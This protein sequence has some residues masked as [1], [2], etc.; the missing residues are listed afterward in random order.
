MMLLKLNQPVFDTATKTWGI[1]T[2]VLI[3]ASHNETYAFQPKGL[4]KDTGL[5]FSQI[6]LPRARISGGKKVL[7]TKYQDAPL[8]ILGTFV[9]DVPTGFK[10]TAISLYYHIT[11]CVHVEI[12]PTTTDKTGNLVTAQNFDI[13]RL[14][15]KFVPKMTEAEKEADMAESPSPSPMPAARPIPTR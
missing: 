15:G 7:E 3:D 5:P 10:G 4:N 13:R 2:M 6:W 11:G 14:T 9:E 8:S 1:L 12:Q